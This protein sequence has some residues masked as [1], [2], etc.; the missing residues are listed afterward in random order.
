MSG[1]FLTKCGEVQKKAT[2][3][4]MTGKQALPRKDLAPSPFIPGQGPLSAFQEGVDTRKW[5]EKTEEERVTQAGD[6]L[7]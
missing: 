5:R 6:A 7:V 4:I 2:V 3:V 1:V